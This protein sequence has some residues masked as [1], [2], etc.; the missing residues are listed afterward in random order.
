[1]R[2]FDLAA[3]N[4]GLVLLCGAALVLWMSVGAVDWHLVRVAAP[5]LLVVIGVTGLL[6]NRK[7]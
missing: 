4:V 7:A 5:I 3:F 6:M 2:R 1:M